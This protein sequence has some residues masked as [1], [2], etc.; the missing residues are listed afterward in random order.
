M[1]CGVIWSIALTPDSQ[2]AVTG[3]EDFMVRVWSIRTG[4]CVRQ[5]A[6]HRGWIM[7]AVVTADGARLLT[8]S[9]DGTAR[10]VHCQRSC[11]S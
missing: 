4:E 8:A 7:E 6:G 1:A 5:M 3:S 9:H 11:R 2:H 10:C